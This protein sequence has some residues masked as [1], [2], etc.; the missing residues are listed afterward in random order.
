MKKVKPWKTLESKYLLKSKWVNFRA[1]TCETDAGGIIEDFYISEYRD[2]VHVIPITEDKKILLNKQYRHGRE[3]I[4]YELP[5]GQVEEEEKDPLEA[6]Q[7]ELLEETGYASNNF[8][9]LVTYPVDPA[10]RNNLIH[11]YIAENVFFK[12][13]A[14]IM[15]NEVIEPYLFGIDEIIDLLDQ[16]E[17]NQSTHI[18]GILMAFKKLG[19]FKMDL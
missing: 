2:F 13:D 17:I 16:G 5:G 9:H 6:A 14:V 8:Y 19:W 12:Q 15:D 11:F 1:D 10:S 4:G 7:R 18:G 3:L